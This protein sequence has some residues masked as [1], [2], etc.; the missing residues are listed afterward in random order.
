MLSI[1]FAQHFVCIIHNL[2]TEFRMC[3]E[4]LLY[5]NISTLL[6]RIINCSKKWIRFLVNIIMLKSKYVFQKLFWFEIEQFKDCSYMTLTYVTKKSNIQSNH[7]IWRFISSCTFSNMTTY[8]STSPVAYNT[9]LVT[10]DN[11]FIWH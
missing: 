9:L 1:S 3:F 8:R 6:Q 11:F 2:E 7:E 4:L 5:H 10:D